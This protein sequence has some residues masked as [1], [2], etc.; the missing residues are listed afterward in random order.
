M[1]ILNLPGRTAISRPFSGDPSQ[2][3]AARRFV[4]GRL[5]DGHPCRDDAVQL[6]GELIAE[7]LRH[8][9][10]CGGRA[11]HVVAV[12]AGPGFARA[13]L[14]TPQ[15]CGCWTSPDMTPG[16]GVHL[17]SLFTDRWGVSAS[18]AGVSVWFELGQPAGPGS[19]KEPMPKTDL[20]H[21]P[22]L[23]RDHAQSPRRP[24]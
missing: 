12:K 6:I 1:T 7:F 15:A 5:G 18:R 17:V 9:A 16:R 4:A 3:G 2:A 20:R 10:V 11:H 19:V 21:H 22:H 23:A 14:V 13:T 8:A 24:A